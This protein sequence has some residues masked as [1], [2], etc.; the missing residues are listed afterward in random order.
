MVPRIAARILLFGSLFLVLV[1]SCRR[2]QPSGFDRNRPPESMLTGAPAESSNAYYRVHLHWYGTDPDGFIVH[3]EY[4]VTDTNRVPGEDTPGATG[5]TRTAR[6]DS[7]FVL[8]ANKIQTLGHRFYVRAVDNEGKTDPTPAWTYFVADD[9]NL[10]E[11]DFISS[12][13]YWITGDGAE[14]TIS[15]TSGSVNAP[16]DTIGVGGR[17]TASWTGHD[18]D[19]GDSVV[20]FYYRRT[21]ESE[22]QGGTLGDTA[23]AYD[24]FRPSGSGL[25]TYFSGN[26]AIYVQAVDEA[27]GRTGPPALRSVVV[28]FSPRAWIVDPGATGDPGRES[29]LFFVETDHGKVYPSGTVLADGTRHVRIR[30]TG[31]DDGRDVRLD[32]NNPS[33]VIGFQ[34]RRLKNGGGPAFKDVPGNAYPGTGHTDEMEYGHLSGNYTYLIRARDE[35]GRTGPADAGSP[36]VTAVLRFDVNYSPFFAWIRYVDGNDQEQPLWNP[37]PGAD[38]AEVSIAPL[39]GGG[40]PAFEVRFLA[41]DDHSLDSPH[42]LDP[43]PLVEDETGKIKSYQVLLNGARGSFLNAV[44][45]SSGLYLDGRTFPVSPA[46]GKGVVSPGTNTMVLSAKDDGGR[47]TALS[48]PFRVVLE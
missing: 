20:G 48:V 13:G 29:R 36:G 43:N 14:R 47:V 42:P 37:D 21:S 18:I 22:Y 35:L 26:A 23:A 38:P 17:F 25:D 34:M 45:D 33:G 8:A 11:V 24:F 15:I 39:P 41:R 27:G 28:N 6:T 4:A 46:A 1:W 32:P 2:E 31:E 9:F 10:P 40:Y 3:Y 7:T 5:Y 12:V 44:P 19:D 30:F 16:T